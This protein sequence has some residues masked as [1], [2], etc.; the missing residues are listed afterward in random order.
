M[1]LSQQKDKYNDK[2]KIKKSSSIS[3]DLKLRNQR[4]NEINIYTNKPKRKNVM[5]FINKNNNDININ[6]NFKL[7]II[8]KNY[9]YSYKNEIMKKNIHN[10]SVDTNYNKKLNIY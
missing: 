10:K 7:S 3:V 1:S 5:K 2:K 8:Y 6:G 9:G 4:K